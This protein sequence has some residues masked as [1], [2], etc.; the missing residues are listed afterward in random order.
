MS[1]HVIANFDDNH[2][3]NAENW[4]HGIDLR[5]PTCWV[6]HPESK[7][8]N[9]KVPILLSLTYF[10]AMVAPAFFFASLGVLHPT[11]QAQSVKLMAGKIAATTSFN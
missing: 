4:V 1:T 6:T 11:N 2:P 5:Q 10:L 8:A 7:L 3:L 9:S